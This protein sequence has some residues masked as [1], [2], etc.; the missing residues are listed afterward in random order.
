MDPSTSEKAAVE[1]CSPMRPECTRVERKPNTNKQKQNK[2]IKT[3]TIDLFLIV[4]VLGGG[5]VPVN[6]VPQEA[7]R[8][9]KRALNQ[10][11]VGVG[12]EL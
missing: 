5:V 9:Q 6:A 2:E 1:Y 7:R 11:K 12:N 8:G 10:P 3:A 4:C